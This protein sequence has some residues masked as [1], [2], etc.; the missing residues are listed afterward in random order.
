MH[1][2]YIHTKKNIIGSNNIHKYKINTVLFQNHHSCKILGAKYNLNAFLA[3]KCLQNG[4]CEVL[5]YP[6]WCFSILHHNLLIFL[7]SASISVYCLLFLLRIFFDSMFV[8]LCVLQYPIHRFWW[9]LLVT[10]ND[11]KRWQEISVDYRQ[12][13]K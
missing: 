11:G 8:L 2:K 1:N 13:N 5:A 3:F 10:N 7:V 6:V 9:L 4:F 12:K